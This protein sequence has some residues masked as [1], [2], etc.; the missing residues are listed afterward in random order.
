M[1]VSQSAPYFSWEFKVFAIVTRRTESA[2]A[3][4]KVF[5]SYVPPVGPNYHRLSCV[6]KRVAYPADNPGM[7]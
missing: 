1:Y 5:R 6:A 4:R 2:A 7:T 3:Y